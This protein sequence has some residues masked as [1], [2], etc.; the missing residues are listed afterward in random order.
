[1]RTSHFEGRIALLAADAA[2]G[3]DESTKRELATFDFDFGVAWLVAAANCAGAGHP[4]RDGRQVSAAGQ[5]KTG[6]F[7]LRLGG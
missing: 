7:D 6:H 3:R 1:M 2:Q 4:P 5:F